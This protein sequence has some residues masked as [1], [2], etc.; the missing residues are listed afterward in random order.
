MA[1]KPAHLCATCRCRIVGPCPRC[2]RTRRRQPVVVKRWY[3][4]ARWQHLRRQVLGAN[5]LCVGCATHG[6]VEI[7]TEVDHRIPHGGDAHRFWDRT[8]LQGMCHPCH[9]AK[10]LRGA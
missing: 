1:M 10:T 2:L 4:T 3:D 9:T 6:L 7:A 8:N 5:P